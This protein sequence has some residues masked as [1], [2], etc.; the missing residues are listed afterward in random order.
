MTYF[1]ARVYQTEKTFAGVER[2]CAQREE[3]RCSGKRKKAGARCASDKTVPIGCACTKKFER[4]C[5]PEQAAA[6]PP[7]TRGRRPPPIVSA[8][9]AVVLWRH[10]IPFTVHGIEWAYVSLKTALVEQD[11]VR[12]LPEN[13]RQ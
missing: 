13:G 5:S 9:F 8:R 11:A 4:I 12:L 10:S 3:K 7:S 6:G 1:M 2:R